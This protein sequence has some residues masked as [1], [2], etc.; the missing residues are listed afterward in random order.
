MI[1][2]EFKLVEGTDSDDLTKKVNFLLEQ[3]WNLSGG[4]SLMHNSNTHR[5]YFYQAVVREIEQRGA[6]D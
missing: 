5:S 6:W 2:Q 4:T 3:G 1:I